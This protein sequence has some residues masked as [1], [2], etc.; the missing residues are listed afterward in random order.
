M[1]HVQKKGFKNG[2]YIEHEDLMFIVE[3]LYP[4]LNLDNMVLMVDVA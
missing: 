4:F 1:E 2:V 3:E